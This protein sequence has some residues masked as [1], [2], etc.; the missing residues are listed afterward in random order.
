MDKSMTAPGERPSPQQRAGAIASL[1]QRAQV[2]CSNDLDSISDPRARQLFEKIVDYL[3]VA[4]E[5]LR[6]FQQQEPPR[7]QRILH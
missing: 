5:A 3:E 2:E 7:S 6:N 4:V 1:I